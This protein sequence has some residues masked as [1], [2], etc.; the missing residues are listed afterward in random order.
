[1]TPETIG[2]I[3]LAVFIILVAVGMNIAVALG[4][5]GVVGVMIFSGPGAGLSMLGI[6]PFRTVAVFGFAALPLFII[7]GEFAF[8][9]GLTSELFNTMNTWFG[10]LPGGMGM[11]IFFGCAAFGAVS[12]SG[13]V[14]SMAMA[15]ASW[16]ELMKFGYD[17]GLASACI[18]SAGS[19]A[20]LIPPSVMGT[21]YGMFTNTP[22]TSVLMAGAIPG[23]VTTL[24]LTALMYV[25]AKLNPTIAPPGP[26][27]TWKQK[28][29]ALKTIWSVIVLAGIVTGGLYGGL[30]TATEA[31]GAGAFGALI[32]ALMQRKLTW[33]RLGEACLATTKMTSFVFL[34]MIG[35]FMF[36]KLLVLSDISPS[37]G[38]WVGGLQ[39]PRVVILI[40]ILTM[41]IFLGM[42]M[43]ATSMLAVSISTVFPIVIG[44]GYDPV[45]FGVV[46]IMMVEIAAI[47]PPVGLAVFA[48]KAV[49]GDEVELW[50]IYK[51]TYQFWLSYIGVVALLI[52]FPQ[53]ALWL[54][55]TMNG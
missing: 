4:L 18:A 36:S 39:A 51:N 52:M 46:F 43:D 38:A 15:R 31:A 23:L 37:L 30:F 27:S 6:V 47:S 12:G 33:H 16:K 24:A 32:I 11:A 44:L 34:I 7:M 42:F 26:K 5:V 19:L 45:W 3:L 55:S 49:L 25:R 50:T 22:I 41:Y 17:R 48:V 21:L 1:M 13:M 28:F 10:R 29:F 35:A 8:H 54:P 53:I 9:A 40:G 20:V 14:G 2:F